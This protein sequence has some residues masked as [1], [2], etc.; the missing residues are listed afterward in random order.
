MAISSSQQSSREKT[1]SADW[2]SDYSN[3]LRS[4]ELGCVVNGELSIWRQQMTSKYKASHNRILPFDTTE[5]QDP[6]Y[7]DR[8]RMLTVK[9]VMR[10][11]G[12]SRGFL[13]TLVRQGDLRPMRFARGVRYRRGDVVSFCRA[14]MQNGDDGK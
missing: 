11:L 2:P 4:N 9:D 1:G 6:A 7:Y 14:R 3:I 10:L 8:D 13:H 5:Q 12:V